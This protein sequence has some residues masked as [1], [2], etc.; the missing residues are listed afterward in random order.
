MRGIPLHSVI[1]WNNAP[2]P[3]LPLRINSTCGVCNRDLSI[4]VSHGTYHDENTWL[5]VTRCPNTQCTA[6]LR[7]VGFNIEGE[8]FTRLYVDPSYED[9]RLPMAGIELAPERIQKS[10][11]DMLATLNGGI[12]SAVA[13]MARK[14]LEGIV[15]M[16]YPNPDSLRDRSLFKLIR[17]LPQSMDLGRPI[18]ELALAMRENG[19]LGAYFDLECDTD[20]ETA[21]KMVELLEYLIEYLY[22]IPKRVGSIKRDFD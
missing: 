16:S 21:R 20:V 5:A 14:T 11:N 8:R 10:Y 4:D 17:D 2:H 3:A 9:A 13:T 22:V 15:R 7:Y 18:N 6:V 12:P 1:A 19:K